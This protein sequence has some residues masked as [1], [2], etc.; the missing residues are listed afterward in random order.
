MVAQNSNEELPV[1]HKISG[2]SVVENQKTL[3]YYKENAKNILRGKS[4]QQEQRHIESF[5]Y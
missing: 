2:N 3:Q 1:S 5:E 4:V